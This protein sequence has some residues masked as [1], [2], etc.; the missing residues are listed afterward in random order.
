LSIGAIDHAK[1][2]NQE[3]NLLAPVFEVL[4]RIKIKKPTFK[5]IQIDS[6]R[7]LK[8]KQ[9]SILLDYDLLC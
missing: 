9:N 8:T 5:M 4:T 6:K 3:E 7:F 2:D 1:Q